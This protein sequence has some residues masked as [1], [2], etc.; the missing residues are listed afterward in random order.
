MDMVKAIEE[1]A[2]PFAHHPP[3]AGGPA[4]FAEEANRRRYTPTALKAYLGIVDRWGLSG[5]QAAALLAVSTSTWERIKRNADKAAPLN[6]DQLTRLSALI[7]IYKGLHLLFADGLADR[8][9]GLANR[10]PLFSGQTPIVSMIEG[11]I[12]QMIDVRRHVDALR[13]AL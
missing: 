3:A 10:G 9:A 8:W 13:G 11:G 2:I 4:V 1:A 12:P 7:G 5:A 6:Q